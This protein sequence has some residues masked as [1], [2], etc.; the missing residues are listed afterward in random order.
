MQT[1]SR[2]RWHNL[3][4]KATAFPVFPGQ[5]IQQHQPEALTLNG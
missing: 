2:A 3:E 4:P 5:P 1:N